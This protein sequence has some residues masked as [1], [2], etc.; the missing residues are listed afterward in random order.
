MFN[1]HRVVMV[2]AVV[3]KV[4]GVRVGRVSTGYALNDRWVLTCAHGVHGAVSVKV[5]FINWK[6]KD[7]ERAK[8]LVVPVERFECEPDEAIDAAILELNPLGDDAAHLETYLKRQ[9]PVR[10]DAMR[11]CR[12]RA[13]KS[14]GFPHAAEYEVENEVENEVRRDDSEISG[15]VMELSGH[16]I[17]RYEL[18][19]R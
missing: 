9:P 19:S 4:P 15:D 13:Y 10:V 6:P 17:E 8:G 18:K 5:D 1:P 16:G 11:E 3:E 7:R 12:G 2:W 14:L